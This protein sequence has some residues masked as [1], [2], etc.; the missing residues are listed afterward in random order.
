MNEMYLRYIVERKNGMVPSFT[1]HEPIDC[2]NRGRH[3]A[4]SLRAQNNFPN[5]Q[6]IYSGFTIVGPDKQFIIDRP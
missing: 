4:A 3:L 5:S 2:I 1:V 6:T